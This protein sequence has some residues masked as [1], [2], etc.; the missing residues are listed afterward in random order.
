MAARDA[1]KQAPVIAR[2]HCPNLAKCAIPSP[3]L[4]YKTEKLNLR[5]ELESIHRVSDLIDRS[6]LRQTAI[7]GHLMPVSATAHS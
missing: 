2:N 1:V 7:T 3:P 4:V 6:E 5:Y